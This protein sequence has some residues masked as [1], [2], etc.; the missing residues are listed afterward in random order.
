MASASL[1]KE[2]KLPTFLMCIIK[3]MPYTDV[4]GVIYN[5]NESQISTNSI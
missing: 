3:P 5:V 4:H 2:Q 1:Q